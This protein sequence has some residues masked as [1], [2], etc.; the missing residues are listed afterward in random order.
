MIK[1]KNIHRNDDYS[2]DEKNIMEGTGKF[3][4]SNEECSYYYNEKEFTLEDVEG[5]INESLNK[6]SDAAVDKICQLACAWKNEFIRDYPDIK[7]SD[8]LLNSKGRDILKFMHM[9]MISI[10]RNPFDSSDNI[11]G[12]SIMGGTDWDEENGM[13]III[14]GT[15]VLEVREFLGYDEFAIWDE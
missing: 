11:F 9:G 3:F 13:E 14:K 1:L 15:E 8:E 7:F 2:D 4:L 5:Y 6:L 10:Y 12:A